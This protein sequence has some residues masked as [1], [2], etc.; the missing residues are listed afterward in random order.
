MEKTK[1]GKYTAVFII[2]FVTLFVTM[3]R[4]DKEAIEQPV[5][6]ENI[7]GCYIASI[8]K[9][10]YTLNIKSQEGQNFDG[11]LQFKNFQK[12][13]S[14]GTYAG[15]YVDQ[16]L[17]G[18]YSFQS[19]GMDSVITTTFKKFGSDFIRGIEEE[20][21]AISYDATAST[22]VFKKGECLTN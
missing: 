12:D 4:R 17:S 2:L 21:G 18:T 16:T 3:N 9:D 7:T 15:T 6:V 11:T 13:S 1:S 19:E 8:D 5:A 14:S 10:V 22:N 20:G